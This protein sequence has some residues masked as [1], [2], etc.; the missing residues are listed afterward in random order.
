MSVFFINNDA[1]MRSYGEQNW[2]SYITME[3]KGGWSQGATIHILR[4]GIFENVRG[5]KERMARP[6]E[7]SRTHRAR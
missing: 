2:Y 4:D 1:F 5:K 7:S 3:I 6:I